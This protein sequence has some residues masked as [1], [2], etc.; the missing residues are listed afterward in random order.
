MALPTTQKFATAAL[1]LASTVLTASPVSHSFAAV[2]HR[3]TGRIS[4]GETLAFRAS[5]RLENAIAYRAAG[6][7]ET[8]ASYRGS[9]RDIQTIG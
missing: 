6:R 7:L 8:V 9:E 1:F 3:G 4:A 2:A 5:G